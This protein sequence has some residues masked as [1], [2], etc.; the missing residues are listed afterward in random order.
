MDVAKLFA[1]FVIV[2]DVVIVVAFLP[3]M[4]ASAKVPF[5]GSLTS[6]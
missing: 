5:S 6:R 3:E 1:E 4:F 2:A